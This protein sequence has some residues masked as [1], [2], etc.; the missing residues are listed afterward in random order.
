MME[1]LREYTKNLPQILFLAASFNIGQPILDDI[2]INNSA[3]LESML[4]L[5][6]LI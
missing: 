5:D 1:H 4:R 6:L 2:M 3:R